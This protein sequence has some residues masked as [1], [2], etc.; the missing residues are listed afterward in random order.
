MGLGLPKPTRLSL[1]PSP[2][3]G[4]SPFFLGPLR[5]GRAGLCRKHFTP[6]KSAP[7]LSKDRALPWAVP[8]GLRGSHPRRS[9]PPS[10]TAAWVSSGSLKPRA[11]CSLGAF[12]R[13][14]ASASPHG[15]ALAL[16]RSWPLLAVVQIWSELSPSRRP[17]LAY[18][19][20]EFSVVRSNHNPP[21]YPLLTAPPPL[22][23]LGDRRRAQGAAS[24]VR[25]SEDERLSV[26]RAGPTELRA[27]ADF[28]T[29][30]TCGV[31]ASTLAARPPRP[32]WSLQRRGPS[33]CARAAGWA[34]AAASSVDGCYAHRGLCES[35]TWKRKGF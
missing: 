28:G 20:T 6:W 21:R 2:R 15:N 1:S 32:T 11:R 5:G 35:P 27:G 19:P 4:D 12:G 30:D 9:R 16:P 14:V 13:A 31:S 8:R 33:L 29:A 23:R 26:Y 22:P 25:L 34:M 3:H 18:G 24:G 7:A 10:G 17:A